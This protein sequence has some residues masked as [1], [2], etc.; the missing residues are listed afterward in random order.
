MHPR[1]TERI[2]KKEHIPYPEFELICHYVSDIF[3]TFIP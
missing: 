2:L 1:Y 3:S